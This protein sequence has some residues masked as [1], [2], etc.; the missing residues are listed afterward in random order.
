[1]IYWLVAWRAARALGDL[2]MASNEFTYDRAMKYEA[3]ETPRGWLREGSHTVFEE[4]ALYLEQPTYGTSYMMGKLE[5][6]Q[7]LSDYAKKMGTAFSMRHF[8]DD[9]TAV[10]LIPTSLVRWQMTGLD[11]DIK[12]LAGQGTS[13]IASQ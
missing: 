11:N 6:E 10:G 5:A 1:M 13:R 8:M 7:L 3:D 12:W 4:Q 9:F 2:R